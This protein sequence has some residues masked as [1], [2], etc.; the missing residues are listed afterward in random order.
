MN[1]P[2]NIYNFQV[3]WRNW[4]QNEAVAL[5]AGSHA[6]LQ[7]GSGDILKKLVDG[8]DVRLNH[9]V[10]RIEWNDKKKK[11]VV[12]CTGGSKHIADKVI[13]LLFIKKLYSRF[14][15]LFLLPFSKNETSF[16]ILPF[17][18]K[19]SM[20]WIKLEPAS[21][22]KS[23]WNFLNVSGR[24]NLIQRIPAMWIILVLCQR[25]KKIAACSICS[26]IFRLE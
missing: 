22:K 25:G 1:T 16:L 23:P 20:L 6:L 15:L 13:F 18:V 12:T 26:T 8:T 24:R 11:M 14:L 10:T 3:S 9:E 7:D 2:Q 5:F 4:D 21:L 17:L 19:K